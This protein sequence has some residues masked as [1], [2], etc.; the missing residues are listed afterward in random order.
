M[1]HLVPISVG[2]AQQGPRRA[3][4]TLVCADAAVCVGVF[5]RI[6]NVSVKAA[7]LRR[8]RTAG[9]ATTIAVVDA[10]ASYAAPV[11]G[12]DPPIAGAGAGTNGICIESGLTTAVAVT[13][14]RA[15]S[16]SCQLWQGLVD[17]LEAE[18]EPETRDCRFGR[19]CRVHGDGERCGRRGGGQL[20]CWRCWRRRQR[21][22]RSST[23]VGQAEGGD[24]GGGRRGGRPVRA[25]ERVR[26]SLRV[27]GHEQ[28]DREWLR[29]SMQQR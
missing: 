19:I 12:S 27:L 3:Q 16:N 4:R 29:T 28:I 15:D 26:E 24:G 22:E 5:S 17:T 2:C 7:G 6:A 11:Y 20:A 9:T 10:A 1:T 8:M 21:H 13:V 18:I 23:D 25:S 14:R